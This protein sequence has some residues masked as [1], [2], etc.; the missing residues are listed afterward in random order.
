MQDGENIPGFSDLN[1]EYYKTLKEHKI[2]KEI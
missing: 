2:S 1:P